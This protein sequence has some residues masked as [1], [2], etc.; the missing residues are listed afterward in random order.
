MGQLG[1]GAGVRYQLMLRSRSLVRA[2]LMSTVVAATVA[3]AGCAPDGTLASTGNSGSIGSFVHN[4]FGSKS[5][6]QVPV[7]HNEAPIEPSAPKTKPATSK[8]KHP[9]VAAA[10]ADGAKLRAQPANKKTAIALAPKPSPKRQASAEPQSTPESTTPSL[11]SGAAPTVPVGSFDNR[12][13]S[14]R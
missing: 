10:R 2:L 4:L 5:E 14:S 1:S 11:L 9:A 13:S 7:A 8:R 3:L 6:D 12:R